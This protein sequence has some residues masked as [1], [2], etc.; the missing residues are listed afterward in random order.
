MTG[1]D[2]GLFVITKKKGRRLEESQLEQ[3]PHYQRVTRPSGVGRKWTDFS[4]EAQLVVQSRT[5]DTSAIEPVAQNSS[6]LQVIVQSTLV[7]S[8]TQETPIIKIQRIRLFPIGRLGQFGRHFCTGLIVQLIGYQFY[9][10][11]IPC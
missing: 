3:Q 11:A 1:V 4:C 8:T 9:S 10:H 6:Y 5:M 7:N 2:D